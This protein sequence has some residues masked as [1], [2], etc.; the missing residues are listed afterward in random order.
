MNTIEKK[1]TYFHLAG[2]R[3]LHFLSQFL[4]Q[5][6]YQFLFLQG[7]WVRSHCYRGMYSKVGLYKNQYCVTAFF[8]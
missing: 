1:Y 5:Y 7:V 8:V 4:F 6:P 2:L 3:H